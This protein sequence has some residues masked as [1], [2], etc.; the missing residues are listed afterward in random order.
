MMLPTCLEMTGSVKF[1]DENMQLCEN[2]LEFLYDRQD[3]L[4]VGCLGLRGVG[5]STV[6]SLLTANYALVFSFRST[7]P[8]R[9]MHRPRSLHRF[10]ERFRLPNFLVLRFMLFV[11][12]PTT[13]FR[14]ETRPVTRAEPT[15]P[16]ALISS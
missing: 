9:M 13:S 16:P 3:F 15:V 10:A 1:M 5:K 8:D 14:F 12:G 7:F 11:P 4:V 6:M 2:A